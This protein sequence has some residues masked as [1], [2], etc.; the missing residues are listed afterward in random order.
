MCSSAFDKEAVRGEIKTIKIMIMITI[1][2]TI[3][4]HLLSVA[5][6]ILVRVV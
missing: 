5:L 1:G 2:V 3:R 4:L 6:I